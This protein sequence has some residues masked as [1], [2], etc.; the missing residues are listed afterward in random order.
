MRVTEEGQV[1]IPKHIR[2]AAGVL[3]GS[4]VTSALPWAC[5]ALAAEALLSEYAPEWARP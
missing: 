4:E 5:A 2:V 3:P 1:T